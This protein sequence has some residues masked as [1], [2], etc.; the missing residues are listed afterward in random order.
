MKPQT[1]QQSIWEE[2]AEGWTG[3]R[4][5]AVKEAEELAAKWKA[6][7]ILDI[8]CGNGRNL[9]P[10]AKAGFDCHGVDF[11]RK[12]IELA[13]ESFERKGLAATFRTASATKLPYPTGSF[14][15]CLSLAVL[16]HI[17]NEKDRLKALSEM[18]RILRP[19]GK[20]FITVWNRLQPR[21]LHAPKDTHVSWSRKGKVYQ[22]YYHLFEYE[23]LRQLIL[24]ASFD[25]LESGGPIGK[26]L[27]FIVEKSEKV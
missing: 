7:R 18:K 8:G 26:N 24:K 1:S 10:F 9:I 2:I 20:A 25:I 14:D 13:N 15:Y 27:A 17:E 21:F 11:S 12:M 5:R 19:G 6:G 23:E 22:R 16:H 3:W 4:H